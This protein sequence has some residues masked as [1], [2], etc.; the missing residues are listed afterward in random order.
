MRWSYPKDGER[1]TI[2]K[3]LIVPVQVGREMRWLEWATMEQRYIVGLYSCFW[4]TERFIDDG[5]AA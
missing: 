3:F 1:R 5:G 2:S 4:H